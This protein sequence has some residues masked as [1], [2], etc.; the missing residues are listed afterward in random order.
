MRRLIA[1]ATVSL[2][3]ALAAAC[4][5]SH[6]SSPPGVSPLPLPRDCTSMLSD[7]GVT[8]ADPP[9]GHLAPCGCSHSDAHDVHPA[10]MVNRPCAADLFC[11]YPRTK[12]PGED[13]FPGFVV[14]GTCVLL[15]V[16]V[17]DG[18]ACTLVGDPPK[19]CAPGL[20]CT[21]FGSGDLHCIQLQDYG[22]PC[23]VYVE[24]KSRNCAVGQCISGRVG[25]PCDADRDD[26]CLGQSKLPGGGD[27]INGRCACPSGASCE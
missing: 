9:A 12:Y 17:S 6:E 1:I 27:C 8:S 5:G 26:Q 10:T 23:H 15:P 2:C 22:G 25:D 13:G 16:I 24:C 20:T 3:L 21:D 4:N 19:S 11:A 7:A 14:E 18:Q